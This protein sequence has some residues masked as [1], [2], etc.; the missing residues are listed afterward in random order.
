M[1]W[2]DRTT[3]PVESLSVY[4][5]VALLMDVPLEAFVRASRRTM[6]SDPMLMTSIIGWSRLAASGYLQQMRVAVAIKLSKT[7]PLP[8][9]ASMVFAVAVI[10]F[11]TPLLAVSRS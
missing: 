1:L 4:V 11:S 5:T 7:L 2:L 3:V 9:R 10:L 6:L 8:V